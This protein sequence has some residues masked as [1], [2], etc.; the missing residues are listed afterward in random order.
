[1]PTIGG[2][3]VTFVERLTGK[4]WWE[5]SPIVAVF[6][7][8]GESASPKALFEALTWGDVC[9]LV[10]VMVASWG[11]EGTPGDPAAMDAL[12]PELFELAVSCIQRMTELMPQPGEP[13]SART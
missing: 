3:E 10:R 13:A 2:K 8:L 12:G 5:L 7:Q 4:A 1:M 11:F 9:R 6:G